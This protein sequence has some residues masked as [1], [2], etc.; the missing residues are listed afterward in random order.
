MVEITLKQCKDL[1]RNP[2]RNPI[3]LRKLNPYVLNGLY[4]KMIIQCKDIFDKLTGLE[5]P[6]VKEE[7]RERLRNILK[8]ALEPIFKNNESLLN[9][10]H[11][12]RIIQYYIEQLN[13]CVYIAN[14]KLI[15]VNKLLEEKV[16]F[17]K[18]IGSESVYGTAYLNKGKGLARLLQFSIKIMKNSFKTEV[19][20]LKA[21]SSLVEKQITPNLPITYKV[22]NCAKKLEDSTAPDIIQ[23]GKYYVVINELANGDMHS[24]FANMY[25]NREYESVI[26]Q[27]LLSLRAFHK[28]LGYIHND[29]HLGNFLWHK[30]KEGGFWHYN[31]EGLDIFVPNTGYLVVL[32][33]PG[34]AKPISK[35]NRVNIDYYRVLTLIKE[36]KLS[37]TY[38]K[39]GMKPVPSDA[40]KPF[41]KLQHYVDTYNKI[42]EDTVMEFLEH[43]NQ[44][45]K[46][47]YFNKTELPANAIILNENPYII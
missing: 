26:M 30:V 12:A 46:H 13:P 47:I 29:A 24:W 37:N 36:M 19:K 14:D 17:E 25:S 35:R 18:Q 7:Y 43:N 27:L 39:L 3:T 5:T 16:I 34:L 44:Y 45:F 32:W 20:L 1:K 31:S 40:L 23:K 4:S 9:R 41:S 38:K 11:F 21:M 10:L 42:E 2:N 8:K 33:D 6:E 28:H 22:F 15:L